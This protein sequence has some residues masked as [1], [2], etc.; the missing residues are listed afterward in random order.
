M[1]GSSRRHKTADSSN[2]EVPQSQ[3][4]WTQEQRRLRRARAEAAEEGPLE[5]ASGARGAS[6]IR[7]SRDDDICI[8]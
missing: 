7:C 3:S 6:S 5:A 2:R 8:K 1:L 4:G